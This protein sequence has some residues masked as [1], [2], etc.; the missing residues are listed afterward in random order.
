MIG[1][2]C[3]LG[4]VMVG[5]AHVSESVMVRGTSLRDV[6]TEGAHISGQR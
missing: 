3:H 4:M 6:I 2:A 5:D 1:G